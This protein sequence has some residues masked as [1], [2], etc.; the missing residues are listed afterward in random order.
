MIQP[1]ENQ[2]YPINAR[3]IIYTVA[4]TGNDE[5]A[6]RPKETLNVLAMWDSEV[7]TQKMGTFAGYVLVCTLEFETDLMN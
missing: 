5:H 6:S 1:R 4:P 2:M 3:E 7:Y